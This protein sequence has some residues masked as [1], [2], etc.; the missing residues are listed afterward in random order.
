MSRT[1]KLAVLAGAVLA[2]ALIAGTARAQNSTYEI[3]SGEVM[4]VKG[5]N[6]IVKA[7]DGVK[8]FWIADDFTFDMNGQAL[9]VH[10]LKPGMKLTA[11][12]KTTQTPLDLTLTEL[13]DAT[14]V[15][16][17]G[18]SIV[19]RNADTGQ[20]QRFTNQ[21][22]KEMDLV[23]YK[24]G[25]VV[26]PMSLRQGDKV[27]ALII[28]KLPPAIVTDKE[29]AVLAQNPEP[30]APAP[31]PAPVVVAQAAP[32]PPPPAPEPAKQL[33]KTGSPLPLI[34]LLGVT[35]L[36]AASLLTIKRKLENR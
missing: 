6:L 2:V 9:T 31:K 3:K 8:E 13:R 15:H 12:V 29:V 19:F 14:V 24:D 34:A 5:N 36:G 20:Y 28:T 18:N 35:A 23:V 25:S 4:A 10:Q 21:D 30:P 26:N 33:P 27:S 7:P 16:T 1:K 22:M 17:I 11:L 32:P